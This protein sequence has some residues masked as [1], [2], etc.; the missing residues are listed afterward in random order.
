MA[1]FKLGAGASEN[2]QNF[3]KAIEPYGIKTPE[4]SALRKAGF[5]K[6]DSNG[7]G[8]ASLAELENF[9]K[10]ALEETYTEENNDEEKAGDL[11][12]LFRPCF[13]RAFSLAKNLSKGN[14]KVLAGTKSATTDDYISFSEFRVF[15]VYLTIYA[16]MYDIFTL[17]DGENAGVTEEDDSRISL[18]EFLDRWQTLGGYSFKALEGIDSQESATALFHAIDSNNGDFILFKEWSDYI[19]DQEIKAKTHI[20]KLLSGDLQTTKIS[21]PKQAGAVR[22]PND[23]KKQSPSVRRVTKV[24]PEVPKSRVSTATSRMTTTPRTPKTPATA[25]PAQATNFKSQMKLSQAV[26]GVYRPYN[27]SKELKDFMRSFQPYTEKSEEAKRLRKLGFR[28][29]DTNGTGECSLAEMDG[30]ILTNLKDDYGPKLGEKL[31]K[32]FRPC[33]IVAFAGAKHLKSSAKGNDDDYINFAEFRIF[34]V[35]LCIYAGM[36]DAFSTLDGGGSGITEDDDRRVEKK[37]WLKG[38]LHVKTSGFIG[39][40]KL[41]DKNS[42]MAAFE[43]MDTNSSGRVLFSDFCHYLSKAEVEEGTKMGFLFSGNGLQ[44]KSLN[45]VENS[46]SAVNANNVATDFGFGI[47]QDQGLA[48]VASDDAVEPD[49]VEQTTSADDLLADESSDN[50]VVEEQ[51]QAQEQEPVDVVTDDIVENEEMENDEPQE[52]TVDVADDIADDG[53]E[54]VVEAT[55]SDDLLIDLNPQEDAVDVVAAEDAVEENEIETE[56]NDE[57]DD[58][59]DEPAMTEEDDEV[60]KTGLADETH[61]EDVLEVEAAQ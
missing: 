36:L 38:Y 2:L 61:D 47:D 6:A 19:K 30:F 35:Y 40:G 37:E 15:C 44:L 21:T 28:K 23:A 56:P 10:A 24:S 46:S 1:D 39:L 16:A 52:D 9:I 29:C 51:E 5:S 11:F 31:F 12:R 34:N 26:D 18:E 32:T 45:A 33:Y 3:V 17:V 57:Q 41:A 53:N 20:G 58:D 27:A 59:N 54:E 25:A 42:A 14:G 43:S 48:E 60:E 7:T 49:V 8:M 50:D 13:I 4:G 22:S 55:T